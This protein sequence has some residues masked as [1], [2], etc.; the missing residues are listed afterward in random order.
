MVNQLD[1]DKAMDR[2]I[3]AMLA[4]SITLVACPESDPDVIVG[5][6]IFTNDCLHYIYVK[7]SFRG[8]GVGTDLIK[9]CT[10]E[11]DESGRRYVTAS[12]LTQEG[13]AMLNRLFLWSYNPYKVLI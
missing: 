4:Q 10:F 9:S 2:K 5:Y 8:M 1:H 11:P 3:N 12:H 13:V 7:K 6:V